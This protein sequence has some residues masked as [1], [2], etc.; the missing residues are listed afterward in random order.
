MGR[1]LVPAPQRENE[2][3][4]L[5]LFLTLS[6]KGPFC[7]VWE[8]GQSKIPF[9]SK[10]P[11]M[12]HPGLCSASLP[13]HWAQATSDPRQPFPWGSGSHW[14]INNPVLAARRTH[15]RAVNIDGCDTV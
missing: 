11:R 14:D 12:Q 5:L 8:M 1:A 9:L 13:G 10:P 7:V 15:T 4:Q 6:L 3:R 2:Q